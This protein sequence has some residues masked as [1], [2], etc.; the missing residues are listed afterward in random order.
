M[1][2]KNTPPIH[3]NKGNTYLKSREV[4]VLRS[5][6]PPYKTGKWSQNCVTFMFHMLLIL[7]LQRRQ[8][9]SPFSDPYILLNH[10]EQSVFCS[11]TNLYFLQ[12]NWYGVIISFLWK[13]IYVLY[14]FSGIVQQNKWEIK[15]SMH[16][17]SQEWYIL[18]LAIECVCVY[19][20]QMILKSWGGFCL[21][22]IYL[23]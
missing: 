18:K 22:A 19:M 2:T 20:L 15:M 13:K 5:I 14:R 21:T 10:I 11:I 3:Y 1:T 8:P 9:M 7:W 12:Q 17:C 16:D 4:T 6:L 23:L